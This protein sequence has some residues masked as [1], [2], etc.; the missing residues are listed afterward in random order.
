MGVGVWRHCP[1]DLPPGWRPGSHFLEAGWT[2]GLVW[3]GVGNLSSHRD[4]ISEPCS[5]WV[6][7]PTEL[8][9]PTECLVFQNVLWC[10]VALDYIYESLERQ[11]WN[12]KKAK[13]CD[14]FL[15]LSIHQDSSLD[16][17]SGPNYPQ[18][19]FLSFF[20]YV[21][22]ASLHFLCVFCCVSYY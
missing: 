2:P 3:T 15:L 20:F 17:W 21:L 11:K 7:V 18:L 10:S 12:K 5:L 4:S 1:A 14:A 8:S 13:A 16:L 9:R 22:V 19:I 6:G